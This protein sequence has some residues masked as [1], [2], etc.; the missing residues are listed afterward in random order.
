VALLADADDIAD[1]YQTA[2][3]FT[4]GGSLDL[5]IWGEGVAAT[6]NEVV[7][8]VAELWF[9]EPDFAAVRAEHLF[10]SLDGA[11]VVWFAHDVEGRGGQ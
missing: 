2:R 6:P 11:V 10:V 1:P 7:E 8:S 5:T 9:M 4:A 3:F